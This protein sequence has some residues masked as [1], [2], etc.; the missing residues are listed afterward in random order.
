MDF[1]RGKISPSGACRFFRDPPS[2]EKGPRVSCE[3]NNNNKKNGTSG[4]KKKKKR[5]AA[6]PASSAHENGPVPPRDAQSQPPSSEPPP[7]PSRPTEVRRCVHCAPQSQVVLRCTSNAHT[8]RTT[9]T[10]NNTQ[11]LQ[12]SAALRTTKQVLNACTQF[13]V[14]F[15]LSRLLD[16]LSNIRAIHAF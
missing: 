3:T 14:S 7:Q 8:K 13:P 6:S 16:H 1:S 15:R 9:N 5:R 11:C 2:P 10:R 4:K 12:C